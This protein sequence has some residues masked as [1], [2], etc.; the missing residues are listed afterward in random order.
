M[1]YDL[2]ISLVHSSNKESEKSNDTM[3]QNYVAI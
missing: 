1:N 2:I 3:P